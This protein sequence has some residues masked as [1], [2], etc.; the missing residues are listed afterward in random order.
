MPLP[1]PSEPHFPKKV[2]GCHSPSLPSPL[3]L[4]TQALPQAHHCHQHHERGSPTASM[5]PDPMDVSTETLLRL[6]EVFSSVAHRLP[7]S[8]SAILSLLLWAQRPLK[9]LLA[10]PSHSHSPGFTHRHPPGFHY[11]QWHP[12]APLIV[13][14][15]CWSWKTRDKAGFNLC[16]GCFLCRPCLPV[17]S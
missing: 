16:R 15:S 6:P 9:A 7:K 14:L 5:L 2:W 17:I 13:L 3:T 4:H 12:R 11:T 10:H 8:A 1:F